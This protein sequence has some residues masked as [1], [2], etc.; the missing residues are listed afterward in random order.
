MNEK[1]NP[2][3]RAKAEALA[4]ALADSQEYVAWKEAREELDR[5]EAAKIMLRDFQHKQADLQ[6]KVLSGQTPTEEEM[7]RLQEAYQLVALNPYVRRVIEAEA[8]FSIMLQEVQ[9]M[10]AEAVGIEFPEDEGALADG[11]SEG[12]I[13]SSPSSGST[14]ERPDDQG[15][16]ARGRLWVPGR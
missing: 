13:G 14:G 5:H 8:A 3:V 11:G 16:S 9:R 2:E 10:L 12:S 1:I 4:E 15:G 7:Q 6:Q